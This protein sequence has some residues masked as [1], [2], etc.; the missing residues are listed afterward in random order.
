[1]SER[2]RLDRAG[3]APR[4]AREMMLAFVGNLPGPLLEDA[5]LLVDELVVNALVHGAGDIELAMELTSELLRVSVSDTGRGAVQMQPAL[6]D[7]STEG[8][9]G[10]FIVDHV[11]DSW[12]VKRHAAD[13]GK[14]VWFELDTL[15]ARP[16]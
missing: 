6:S 13:S 8:G 15:R 5:E 12:G 14:T 9:R 2:Y 3:E 11:A 10:L 7:G 4:Q 16:P 1:L